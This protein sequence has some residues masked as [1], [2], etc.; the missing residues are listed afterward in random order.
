MELKTGWRE[1]HGNRRA[2]IDVECAGHPTISSPVR[3]KQHCSLL[4]T[5][6]VRCSSALFID[7]RPCLSSDP[8]VTVVQ[9]LE[10]CATAFSLCSYALHRLLSML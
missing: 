7:T 2:Y 4:L 1:F 9:V 3:A 8:F 10:D 6:T 5:Q